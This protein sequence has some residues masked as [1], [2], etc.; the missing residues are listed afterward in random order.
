VPAD[1]GLRRQVR[2]LITRFA[3]A[4]TGYLHL[5]HVL[6]AMYVWGVARAD[7]A[8]SRVLLRVEDHDRQRSR[9]VFEAAL[10]EDLQW[11]GFVPDEPLVRQ[12]DRDAVYRGALEGLRQRGLI[13]ACDCTRTEIQTPRYPGTCRDRAVP[14][15]TG[16][17]VRVRL[18]P[19]IERF[20]DWR[21]GPVEQRPSEQCG[22]LLVR[23]RAGNWTYQFAAVVDD[24]MQGVTLVV[25]GDDLLD[26]TGRQIQLAQLLGRTDPPAFLHH[27]LIMKTPTQKL[28]KCDGDTGVRELRAKGWSAEEVLEQVLAQARRTSA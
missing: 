16:A 26:S 22:D 28:S 21:H 13:Y 10:V 11:L 23:D 17:G 20:D 5:G 8:G 6:N 25:R 2:P 4:P 12:S 18:E 15:S 9:S 14:E 1:S 7:G 19:T 27:P 24:W 3:P